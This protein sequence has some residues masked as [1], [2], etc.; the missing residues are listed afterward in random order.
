MRLEYAM[1]RARVEIDELK[2]EIERLKDQQ[3]DREVD[4][5]VVELVLLVIGICIGAAGAYAVFK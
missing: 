5:I 3:H 4:V 1:D 2:R